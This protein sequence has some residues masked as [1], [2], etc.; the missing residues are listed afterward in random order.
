MKTAFAAVLAAALLAACGEKTFR[1]DPEEG[2][3]Y[4]GV[5][6]PGKLVERMHGQN[7]AERIGN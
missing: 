3:A 1:P 6:A 5:N 4:N 2:S 7:E